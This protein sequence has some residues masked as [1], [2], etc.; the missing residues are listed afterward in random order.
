MGKALG[1]LM[2]KLSASR[3]ILALAVVIV[4]GGCTTP[5]TNTQPA[6][7]DVIETNFVDEYRIGVGD[8]LQ[9]A[10]WRNPD[11]GVQVPVR[12]DGIVTVPLAGEVK[13]GGRTAAEVSEDIQQRLTKYIREP[14]VSVILSQINADEFLT[15]VRVTGA[16]QSPVSMPFRQGITVLDAVLEAGSVTE[17]A[18]G[19]RSRLFRK[20]DGATR[21]SFP[22]LL[23]DIL[24]RGD[25]ETNYPLQPGDVIT[26]PERRF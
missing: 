9:I 1:V 19:N 26:V 17:F 12:P 23:D 24:T 8:V 16:V 21:S 18:A 25:M 5:T 15:R 10:V 14:L 13:A 22:V 2:R 20:G 3:L 4:V 7:V 6:A 11:L